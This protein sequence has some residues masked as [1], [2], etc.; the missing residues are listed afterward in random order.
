MKPEKA[1]YAFIRF[2]AYQVVEF[3]FWQCVIIY[4]DIAFI[5]QVFSFRDIL[6]RSAS[7]YYHHKQQE[8]K[9][10]PDSEYSIWRGI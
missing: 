6:C 4:D 2:L 8:N 5:K 10:I 9:P 7:G 3:F 1:K